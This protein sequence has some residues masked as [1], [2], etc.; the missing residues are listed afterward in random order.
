MRKHTKTSKV[1]YYIGIFL[2]AAGFAFG[3]TDVSVSYASLSI[4][5]IVIGIIILISTN[6]F[7]SKE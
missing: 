7:K 4:P 5:L 6:F 2:F 1:T 3:T